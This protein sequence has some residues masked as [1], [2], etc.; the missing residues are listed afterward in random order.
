MVDVIKGGGFVDNRE[1]CG[2]RVSAGLH[3]LTHPHACKGRGGESWKN[4]ALLVGGTA[5]SN[6]ACAF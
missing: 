4:K 3:M 2:G 1:L 6:Y 5:L